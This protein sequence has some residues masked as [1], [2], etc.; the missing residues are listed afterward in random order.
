[1][2]TVVLAVVLTGSAAAGAAGRSFRAGLGACALALALGAPWLVMAWPAEALPWYRQGRGLLLDGAGGLG[3]G[4]NL[5]YAIWWPLVFLL[6]WALPLGVLGA[7]AGG[8]LARRRARR[9][10][11]A[12]V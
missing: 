3:V 10:S 5:G 2:T 7:A 11:E 1:V 6:L 8:A 9:R 12:V 4:A